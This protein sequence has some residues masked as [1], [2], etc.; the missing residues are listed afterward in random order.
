MLEDSTIEYVFNYY[1][2][3]MTL[4]E[5]T[6]LKHYNTVYKFGNSLS[7]DPKEEKRDFLIKTGWLS[8]DKEVNDLLENGFEY[9]REKAVEKILRHHSSEIFFNNCPKCGKLAR[10]PFAKQCRFCRYNWHDQA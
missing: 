10:T 1:S 7:N 5:K 2:R 9:F 6:A 4:P 8:A 3:F